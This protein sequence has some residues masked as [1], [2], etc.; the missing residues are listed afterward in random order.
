LLRLGAAAV[1]AAALERAAA[2]RSLP[3]SVLKVDIPQARELYGRD[4]ALIR[5]DQYICWRGDR[6]PDDVD[7]LLARVTGF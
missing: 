1:D 6:L 4:L 2:K 5:P 3:L 7:A